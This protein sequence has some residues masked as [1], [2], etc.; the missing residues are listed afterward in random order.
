MESNERLEKLEKVVDLTA[1]WL[2]MVVNK[3]MEQANEKILNSLLNAI[4][5]IKGNEFLV[6]LRAGVSQYIPTDNDNGCE[7]D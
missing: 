3:N 1:E 6:K 7:P 4:L 5:D 2:I